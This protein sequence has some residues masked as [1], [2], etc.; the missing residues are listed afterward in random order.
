MESSSV[1][2]PG[3]GNNTAGCDDQSWS[4]FQHKNIEQGACGRVFDATADSATGIHRRVLQRESRLP[5]ACP[6]FSTVGV[7]MLRL[8]ELGFEK[9]VQFRRRNT[10]P[11][12]QIEISGTPFFATYPSIHPMYWSEYHTADTVCNSILRISNLYVFYIPNLWCHQSEV[13]PDV[14]ADK[15]GDS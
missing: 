2:Q 3:G 7:A 14:H 4:V 5:A 8:F 1:N 12:F 10:F 9:I 15:R 11:G 13:G 6:A